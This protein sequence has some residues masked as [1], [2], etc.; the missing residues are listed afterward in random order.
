MRGGRGRTTNY[1]VCMLS[2]KHVTGAVVRSGQIERD[3]G[4]CGDGLPT[5]WNATAPQFFQGASVCTSQF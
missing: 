5:K 4:V 2:T 1:R 3:F